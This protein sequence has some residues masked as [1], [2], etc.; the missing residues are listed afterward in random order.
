M[1]KQYSAKPA[2]DAKAFLKKFLESCDV[3]HQIDLHV[4]A[5][6]HIK[7]DLDNP[8]FLQILK[9]ALKREPELRSDCD[10]ATIA[11]LIEQLK[12]YKRP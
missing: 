3:S 10:L 11:P 2:V 6:D 8:E 1:N 5:D 4:H 7:F 9:K 12:I